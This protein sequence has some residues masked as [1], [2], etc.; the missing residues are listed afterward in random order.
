M[1]LLE[2]CEALFCSHFIVQSNYNILTS[3]CKQIFRL[4][5]TAFITNVSLLNKAEYD[6]LNLFEILSCNQSRKGVIL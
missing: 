4:F 3:S 1:I 5:T 6:T 2:N